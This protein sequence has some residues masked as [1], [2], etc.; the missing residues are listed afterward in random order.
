MAAWL[1]W[2][3][4]DDLFHLAQFDV[5]HERRI[6]RNHA[7]RAASAIA[8]VGR[9]DQRALPA[10]LH[11]RHALVPTLDHAAPTQ[12]EVER[13]AGV[14]GAVE[15]APLLV[16]FGRVIKPPGVMDNDNF[17][18]RSFRSSS[19]FYIYFLQFSRHG[20]QLACSLG[21]RG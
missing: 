20:I 16:R 15:L 10:N 14:A 18:G 7:A 11:A 4:P 1:R 9:D 17:P 5:E 3:K 8:Q 6:G 12:R 19:L 21:R 2:T 13:L